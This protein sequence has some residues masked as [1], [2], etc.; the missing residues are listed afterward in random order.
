MMSLFDFY[1]KFDLSTC[2]PFI[3]ERKVI[4]GVS[5]KGNQTLTTSSALNI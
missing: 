4:K 2:Q 1:F 5:K 3:K